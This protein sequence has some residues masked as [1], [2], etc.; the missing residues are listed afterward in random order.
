MF[1]LHFFK[2]YH[3]VIAYIVQPQAQRGDEGCVCSRGIL[4]LLQKWMQ[5]GNVITS[6]Q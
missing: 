4:M 1:S 5:S 3:K 2:L 6:Y